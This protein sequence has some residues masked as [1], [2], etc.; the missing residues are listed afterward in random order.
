MFSQA[1]KDLAGNLGTWNSSDNAPKCSN[2]TAV[3]VS[4]T[5]KKIQEI[6]DERKH[7]SLQ[8]TRI[9]QQVALLREDH[10][11]AYLKTQ[12]GLCLMLH[13]EVSSSRL[14]LAYSNAPTTGE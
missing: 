1:I 3:D 11:S 9:E 5:N 4:I 14:P 13:I 8:R 2:L 6:A 12:L 7:A 10:H